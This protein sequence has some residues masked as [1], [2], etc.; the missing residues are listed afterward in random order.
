MSRVSVQYHLHQSHSEVGAVAQAWQEIK[1]RLSQNEYPFLK[2]V[3]QAA[4]LEQIQ[5]KA[6]AWRQRYK[7]LVVLGTGGSSLGAKAL[8]SLT[9]N[10]FVPGPVYFLENVDGTS[11]TGL[12]KAVELDST[13]FLVI[14]KSGETSE[15]LLQA[16]CLLDVLRQ[17]GIAESEWGNHVVVLTEEKNSSLTQ[18][19]DALKLDRLSHDATIGGRFSVFSNV[20]LLPA[21]FSGFDVT[22][23]MKGAQQLLNNADEPL[24][25]AGLLHRQAIETGKNIAVFMPYA[26]RLMAFGRWWAQ[27]W[28]ESLGKKGRGSTPVAALGT[29]DQHSQL[30]LY[31]DG[32]HDK[33]YTLLYL[34]EDSA[35]YPPVMLSQ[36]IQSLS[37]LQ[38]VS[39][40]RLNRTEAQATAQTLI[41]QEMPVRV[42]TVPQ[43]TPHIVGQLTAQFFLET[44][45]V[46]E[47][48]GVNP[49]DQPGVEES[50]VLTRQYLAQT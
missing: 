11:L 30:Q 50:K 29:V 34:T 42:V 40:D 26:D 18:L 47:M 49:F 7:S 38:G 1:S 5:Q 36:P 23:F 39:L 9:E 22:A 17:Q 14:S 19:A 16:L 31:R 44:L 12:L 21:A 27:L 8:C 10:P 46:A 35:A 20:G 43:L 33:T 45:L 3:D 32:P 2:Y 13:L 25:Q 28:A 37:Y 15:T 24:Q 41:N 4:Y 48:L 6:A